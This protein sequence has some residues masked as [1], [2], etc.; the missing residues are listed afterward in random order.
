MFL[1]LVNV[2]APVIY[3]PPPPPDNEADI[4]NDTCHQGIN[5]AKYENI[6]VEV[7]GNN[8]PAKLKTF[9]EANLH[10]V[11]RDNINRA[12][13]DKPTPVQKHTLPIIL[14]GRDLM[15]CAQTGSGKTVC[16]HSRLILFI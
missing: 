15:A 2:R 9:Q 14:A 5:F 16:F 1:N 13:Y 8:P 3:V 10:A 6:A 12:H 4:F 11:C 7:T